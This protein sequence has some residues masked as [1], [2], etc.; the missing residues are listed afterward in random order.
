MKELYLDSASTFHIATLWE[1]NNLSD[2]FVK[3]LETSIIGNIY[4]GRVVRIV[5][6]LQAVFVDIGLNQNAYLQLEDVWPQSKKDKVDISKILYPGMDILVQV[7][8]DS[9]GEKGARLT[10]KPSLA[11]LYLVFRPFSKGIS[12]SKKINSKQFSHE[13]IE[14]VSSRLEIGGVTLRTQ[15]CNAS[16][17]SILQELI[18]L[19]QQWF[20]LKETFLS[21]KIGLIYK[22]DDFLLQI[23]NLCLKNKIFRIYCSDI[24]LLAHIK[25]WYANL[26]VEH[27]GSSYTLDLYTPEFC[28][29]WPFMAS[30]KIMKAIE[31]HLQRKVLL[32]SGGELVIDETEGLTVI[33]VD[34]A[35]CTKKCDVDTLAFEI[36]MEAV[37]SIA[38]ELKIRNIGGSIVIDFIN[39]ASRN[40]RNR[41]LEELKL[42][43]QNDG[44]NTV[45][46]DFTKL[47]LVELSRRR[48]SP[49]LRQIFYRKINEAQISKVLEET[50][51]TCYKIY[52]EVLRL[53]GQAKNCNL[54]N[55]KFKVYCSCEVATL[56]YKQYIE[57][58]KTI[59]PNH[60]FEILELPNNATKS[61]E[62]V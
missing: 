39:M 50:S 27:I 6:N 45:C 46:F 4:K 26:K 1:N 43:L 38:S 61:Y 11:G 2:L 41:I 40:M 60:E 19:K 25:R 24:S 14:F 56:F 16:T 51:Y 10:M 59:A 30:S 12:F 37:R 62:V 20:L 7:V 54:Q 55:K 8:R 13:F 52:G 44:C 18:F 5:Q 57:V 48:T 42:A 58:L 9:F 17:N 32:P 28:D 29:Q 23:K 36:N 22:S 33:D 15:V 3:P 47:G 49:S 21:A 53:I 34:S 31:Q 35:S